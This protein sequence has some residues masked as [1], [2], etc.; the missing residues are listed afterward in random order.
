LCAAQSG[1]PG[2]GKTAIAGS[3]NP[4]PLIRDA[5]LEVNP[6][7]GVPAI[8]IEAECSDAGDDRCRVETRV[9]DVS[10]LQLPA[11]DEVHFREYAPWNRERLVI[12][13]ASTTLD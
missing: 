8:E 11:W 6:R 2:V 4:I 5:W 13:T 1:L 10:G 3:A 7:A 12:D 9:S